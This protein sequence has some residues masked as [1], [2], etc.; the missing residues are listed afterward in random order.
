MNN[1]ALCLLTDIVYCMMLILLV[2]FKVSS[3]MLIVINPTHK[4]KPGLYCCILVLHYLPPYPSMS[5][6]P[7]FIQ[8]VME[9]LRNLILCFC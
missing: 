1:H 9:N 2:M 3:V 7:I 8:F 5:S 4:L 6:R